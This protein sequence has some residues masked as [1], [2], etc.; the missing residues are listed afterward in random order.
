MILNNKNIPDNVA[1]PI[2]SAADLVGV[3]KGFMM[4]MAQQESGFNPNIKAS[5]S[6]ATGLFQFLKGTWASMV[7]K[8][9]SQY[10]IG[11]GDIKDPKANSIMGALYAKENGQE[12]QHAF[13]IV[14]SPTDL[15]AAHFL[16]IDGAKRFLGGA[17]KNNS[18][19]GI[20]LVSANVAKAN[21]NIFYNKDGSAKSAKEVYK[22]FD[23]KVGEP[24]R[25]FTVALNNQPEANA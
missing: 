18:Q 10:G 3:D 12:L 8:Y 4:A 22:F 25:Q 19:P 14:P 16:G 15:Y 17:I 2:L 13:G 21:K 1:K 7:N 24:A 23:K 11:M 5:T 6:S 20:N 9:G